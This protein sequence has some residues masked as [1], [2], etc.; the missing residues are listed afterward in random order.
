MAR[1]RYGCL[2]PWQT[3]PA[4]YGHAALTGSYPTC[5]DDVVLM[6]ESL[7]KRR[8]YAEHD[9]ERFLDAIQNARLVTNAERYYRIMYYGSRAS[10][11]LARHPHVR[12]V[13]DPA[14]LSRPD[15]KAIVGRTIRML[16]IPP[17]PRCPRA[18]SIISG[19]FAGSISAT[20][21]SRSASVRTGNGG[22]GVRL[23]RPDG[24][25]DRAP[26]LAESY[27]RLF[28]ETGLR[29]MLR[30]ARPRSGIGNGGV[31]A[32]TAGARDRGDLPAGN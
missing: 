3:D 6:L 2:T 12:D 32:G 24:G 29:F 15:S 7:A 5:E 13:E 18:A 27:E 8:A 20:G 10:W 14:Q 1:E 23:G 28:H 30:L 19:I 17:R 11:N 22:G 16:A 21:L 25:Q 26:G 9:G 4:T 31:S